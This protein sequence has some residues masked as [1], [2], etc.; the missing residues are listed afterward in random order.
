[1]IISKT[2]SIRAPTQASLAKIIQF[3]KLTGDYSS[4]SMTDMMVLALVHTIEL[5]KNDGIY[6]RDTPIMVSIKKIYINEIGW[7]KHAKES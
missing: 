4:L 6:Y 7:N 1:M 5:E 3:S 2:L